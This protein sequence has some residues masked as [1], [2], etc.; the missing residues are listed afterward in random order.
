MLKT[1]QIKTHPAAEIFPML[2]AADLARLAD[3][4]K[5]QG[6]QHPLVMH[7][8]LLL[9]GRNRLAAC[10]ITDVKPSFTEYE[11]DSPLGFVI[12]VNIKRRQ[13]NPSQR[14][15]V[16]VEIEPMFSVEAKKRMLSGVKDP[17]ADLPQGK[18]APKAR[19]QAADVCGVS[20]RMVQR[21]CPPIDNV[22]KR[23]R[24]GRE[25]FRNVWRCEIP[26]PP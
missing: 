2:P 15:C 21:A 10:K 14:A 1:G 13:L 3:D 8:G 18:P 4:I 7:K 22:R 12:S 11:G 20:P 5:A 26:P 25:F 19:D 9:D 23:A 17:V 6:L 24:G 16:G